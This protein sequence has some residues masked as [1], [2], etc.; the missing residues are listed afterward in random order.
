MA[1]RDKKTGMTKGDM[2]AYKELNREL[3]DK[4]PSTKVRGP[5]VHPNRPHGKEPHGHVGPVDHIPILPD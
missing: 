3:P 2:E 5:E 4:F 1:K